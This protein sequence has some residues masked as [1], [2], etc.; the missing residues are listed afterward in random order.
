M[1]SKASARATALMLVSLLFGACGGKTSGPGAG[2]DAGH[3]AAIHPG[4]GGQCV[5]VEVTAADLTCSIDSD[6]ALASS[7]MICERPCGCGAGA[8]N[9]PAAARFAIETASLPEVACPPC[10]SPGEPRC[11]FGQ[12]T[13]CDSNRPGCGDGG[14]RIVDAGGRDTGSGGDAT[15]TL[16]G[17]RCVEVVLLT[18]SLSCSSSSDC[19]LIQTG[20]VCSGQCECGGSAVSAGELSRYH[21]AT[22]GIVF[23]ACPCEASPAPQCVAGACNACTGSPL[24]TGCAGGG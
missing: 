9:A 15:T 10:A 6:C 24:P 13:L 19:T 7:G 23:A 8:V 22:A 16:D 11:A 21:D 5:N 14:V 4:D 18:Y 17:G 1:T 2:A 20:E 3:D 12:C